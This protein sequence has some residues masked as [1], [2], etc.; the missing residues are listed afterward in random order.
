MGWLLVR[1]EGRLQW[2][3]GRLLSVSSCCCGRVGN[4]FR[5]GP[6]AAA[7]GAAATGGGRLLP[8]WGRLVQ[9]GGGWD[10]RGGGGYGW[11]A[12]TG[13][14]TASPRAVH[15]LAA[16]KGQNFSPTCTAGEK[17]STATHPCVCSTCSVSLPYSIWGKESMA[18]QAQ[19]AQPHT[20]V[21]RWRMG[22]QRRIRT[23]T[24]MVM[25]VAVSYE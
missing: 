22:D 21:P 14:P 5:W 24:T 8:A 20:E 17:K 25:M 11:G 10:R 9:V 6:A 4:R 12:A 23:R 1:A 16:T 2:P 7:M 3:G 15:Q 18:D 13:P 19:P